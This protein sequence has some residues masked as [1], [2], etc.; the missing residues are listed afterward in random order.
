LNLLPTSSLK[1][2]SLRFNLIEVSAMNTINALYITFYSQFSTH[3]VLPHVCPL[4]FVGLPVPH[5][6]LGDLRPAPATAQP[7]ETQGLD[8]FSFI[9]QFL[10]RMVTTCNR[11]Q[12][13]L[14]AQGT[15]PPWHNPN[16]FNI[17]QGGNSIPTISNTQRSTLCRQFVSLAFIAQKTTTNKTDF[18]IQNVF[19]DSLN[20]VI[21]C[22]D[23]PSSYFRTV[24]TVFRTCGRQRWQ[25]ENFPSHL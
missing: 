18:D 8:I 9:D 24:F 7:T 6:Y 13:A 11:G 14:D 16:V 22:V 1:S 2:S 15:P 10:E 19:H 17:G 25:R 20:I 3:F 21:V 5:G 12:N 23:L 4:F